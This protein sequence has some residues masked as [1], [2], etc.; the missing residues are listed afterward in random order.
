EGAV[1]PDYISPRKAE[2]VA[3]EYSPEKVWIRTDTREFDQPNLG[4]LG[5]RENSDGVVLESYGNVMRTPDLRD[6]GVSFLGIDVDSLQDDGGRDALMNAIE[7][8]GEEGGNAETAVLMEETDPGCIE[9]A[10]ETGID[11]VAVPERE[12]GRAKRAV[13]KAEKKFMLDRLREL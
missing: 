1:I 5:T 8:V 4:L 3:R 12:V 9:T 7:K 2:Q 13:A 11:T 6:R 10:V